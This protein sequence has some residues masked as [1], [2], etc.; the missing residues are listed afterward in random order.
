[1]NTAPESMKEQM[2]MDQVMHDILLNVNLVSSTYRATSHV[3][4]QPTH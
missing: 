2:A 4:D 3:D 1:M